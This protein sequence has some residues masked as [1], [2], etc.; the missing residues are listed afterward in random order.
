MVLIALLRSPT[1][2]CDALPKATNMDQFIFLVTCVEKRLGLTNATDAPKTLSLLRQIFFGNAAW[3]TKRNRNK[4]WDDI[5]PTKPWS[6]GDDPTPKLGPKLLT[7]LQDSK[8]VKFDSS[9]SSASIEVS[10]ML[11]GL[12]AMM[13]PEGVAI[14]LTQKF[15]G[16][17]LMSDTLNHALATWAG[18]V[19]SAATNYTICVDFLRFSP[20]YD[21]FFKDLASDADLEGDVDAYAAWAAQ[22][23]SSPNAPVPVPLNLP[24]SEMLM[25]Y[26]RLKKTAGGVAREQRFEVFANFY[27]ANVQGKKMQNRAAFKQNINASVKEIGLLLT[28]KQLREVLQGNMASVGTCA[29]GKQ[30]GQPGTVDVG[31]ILMNLAIASDEMTERFTVW[32]E[33]R[34]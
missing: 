21:D 12:D 6:P 2:S 17:Y 30:I 5:I 14:E 9:A 29:G 8:E 15:G 16:I 4:I 33:K 7:A 27:G 23:Y 13:K 32:I 1:D 20:T 10:H 25:Q 11:T 24:I 34:L 26:Y 19:A 18:D 3:S 28:I 31:T 22:L